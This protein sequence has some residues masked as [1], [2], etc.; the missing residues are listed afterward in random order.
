MLLTLETCQCME[1]A[2]PFYPVMRNSLP[3]LDLVVTLNKCL[4]MQA[5][6]CPS[7]R[8]T[9]AGYSGDSFSSKT[10]ALG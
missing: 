9:S 2:P 6:G 7:P 10:L 5:L 8:G 1:A 4:L 3:V